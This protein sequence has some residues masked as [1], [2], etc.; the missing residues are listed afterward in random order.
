MA[1]QR[2]R[3]IPLYE[4]GKHDL[5]Q[6]QSSDQVKFGMQTYVLPM[7]DAFTRMSTRGKLCNSLTVAPCP[8]PNRTEDQY[9][10]T[11]DTRFRAGHT[12]VCSTS[13]RRF[14]I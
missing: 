4:I 2:Y 6:Y 10:Q 9:F 5:K 3:L 14:S 7:Q 12:Q 11:C 8:E 13:E 1:V